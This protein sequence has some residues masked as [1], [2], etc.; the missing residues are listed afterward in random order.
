MIISSQRHIDNSIVDT[1]AAS[2]DFDVF[3]SPEFVFEGGIY[4]VVL[5]GHHSL[6]AAKQTGNN[7]VFIELD[8]SEHD[9]I[10]LLDDNRANDFLT[11]TAMDSDY[12]DISTGLYIW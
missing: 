9:A 11:T 7:P 4:Q 8:A 10:L 12:Y 1:K 3:V 6:E 2:C 5:D